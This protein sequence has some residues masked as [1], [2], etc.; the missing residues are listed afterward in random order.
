MRGCLILILFS[1]PAIIFAQDFRLDTIK[2]SPED[3][4]NIHQAQ[5]TEQ[6]D[7]YYD[8]TVSASSNNNSNAFKLDKSKLR[9]GANVGLSLSKNYTY[10]G[11]GPQI[12]YQFNK[13]FMAGSGVKYYYLKRELSDYERK[14]NLLGLNV[15]GYIYPVRFI[16]LFTQPE[17]NYIWS[18]LRY[19]TGETLSSKGFAPSLLV[20]AG[21]RLGFTHVTIN[22]DLVQHSNSPHPD[23]FYLAV[24]AFF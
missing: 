19:N 18:N 7:I 2:V 14:N 21:L 4:R 20:G 23:G 3:R 8:N 5:K 16:T 11:I 17:I 15:F 1:L 10:L 12:G 13:Y 6:T 24:S 9:F 22:Y